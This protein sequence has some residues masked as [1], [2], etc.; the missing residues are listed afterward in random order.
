MKKS[1]LATAPYLKYIL[2]I[3]IG[4]G[5]CYDLYFEGFNS[6]VDNFY[7]IIVYFFFCASFQFFMG[8]NKEIQKSKWG[9]VFISGIEIEMYFITLF[10]QKHFAAALIILLGLIAVHVWLYRLLIL[11]N[12]NADYLSDRKRKDKLGLLVSGIAAIVLLIPSCVGVY[13]EYAASSIT[14]E[15]WAAFVE[16]LN[17]EASDEPQETLFEK[18]EETLSEI[19][20]WNSL[21]NDKKIE[22]IYKIGIIELEHLGISDDVGIQ[23][24]ADKIDE[25]TLGYYSDSEKQIVI[26]TAHI[27]SD[28]VEE[29][30]NTISHEVFHAYQYYVVSSVDFDSWFVQNSYY[31][32]DARRW[33]ENIE[34]YISADIDFESYQVQP[35]EADAGLY[36]EQRVNEYMIAIS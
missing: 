34:N 19:S 30:I 15:E 31:F 12:K 7:F 25:Y 29:N 33:K 27:C 2:F 10:A 16:I 17:E 3:W 21:E 8:R 28:S 5:G 13:E 6:Y 23:I 1:I 36:A 18:H 24:Q 22:L 32:E 11:S 9:R 35:L 14:A 4:I 26:N 20:N